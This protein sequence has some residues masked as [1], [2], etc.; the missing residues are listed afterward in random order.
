MRSTAYRADSKYTV[1]PIGLQSYGWIAMNVQHPKLKDVNVRK[2]IREG[3][4]VPSILD[5]VYGGQY[6]RA[7]AMIAPGMIGYWEDAPCYER[8]VDKAKEYLKA[9]GVDTLEVTLTYE[10]GAE[11][12]STAEIVQANL[13]EVGI[14]VE[15][16]PQDGGV[17]WEE[18]YGE[19]APKVP[20]A[21]PD[22]VFDL[23]RPVV[24]HA[25]VH[26]RPGGGVELDVLVQRGVR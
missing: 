8:N 26:L 9:A 4:D 6:Q 16:V 24:R 14:K 7:C 20:R 19:N 10:N 23:S 12:Q 17:F 3:I 11:A 21:D 25:V 22:V 18:G 15:L 5:A 13:A 2:A 1:Y